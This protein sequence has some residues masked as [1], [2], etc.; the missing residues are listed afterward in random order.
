MYVYIY[1]HTSLSL[2]IY[3]YVYLHI[4]AYLANRVKIPGPDREALLGLAPHKLEDADLD[5]YIYIYIYIHICIYLD[6]H[7]PRRLSRDPGTPPRSA[8][9]SAAAQTRGC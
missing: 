4:Y 8:P 1:T 5:L 3:I 6:L 7:I 9:G 2:Y